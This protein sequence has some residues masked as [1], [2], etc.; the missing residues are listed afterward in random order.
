MDPITGALISGGSSLLGG[1]MNNL[2]GGANASAANSQN[3]GN[4]YLQAQWNLAS[5]QQNQQ[6]M[7]QMSNTAYQR[8]T[9]D[10][11][12]AGLNP[13]L[14]YG[15]GGAASSPTSSPAQMSIPNQIVKPSQ[16]IISPA[17]SS[18]MQMAS[19]I[20]GIKKTETD[21]A[22]VGASTAETAARTAAVLAEIP[23]KEKS[24]ALAAAQIAA[25]QAA[26]QASTAQ[27]RLTSSQ[28]AAHV[29]Y[30]VTDPGNP[31]SFAGGI[32]QDIKR[33]LPGAMSGAVDFLKDKVA[34]MWGTLSQNS[35]TAKT[36]SEKKPELRNNRMGRPPLPGDFSPFY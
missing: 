17:V 15:S 27:A 3:L 13:A 21:R 1:A 25:T 8:G 29:K 6:W 26:T 23:G 36:L 10:M 18:A 16:D 30:G 12:A 20:E 5:Q 19:V 2:W 7:T 9:A 33:E 35:P 28:A 22:A 14:M 11:K 32:Y 24:G 31:K 4:A 34:P